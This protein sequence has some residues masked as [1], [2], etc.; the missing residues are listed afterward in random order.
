VSES[1]FF[2]WC[3]L[4]GCKPVPIA[5]NLVARFVADIGPL[6]IDMVWPAVKEIS[7]LHYTIGLADPTLGHPVAT[8]VAAIGNVEAPH[9]WAKEYKG[10]FATL[11]YDVQLYIAQRD[12]QDRKAVAKAQREAAAARKEA[13][14][15]QAKDAT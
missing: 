15:E 1:L 3:T 8:A 2:N 4:Q 7:R 6:G 11:P 14:P 12:K 9:S 13:A 10:R 5:P